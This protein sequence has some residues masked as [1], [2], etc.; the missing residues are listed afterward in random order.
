MTI[1]APAS[2]VADLSEA[3]D[4]VANAAVYSSAANAA[5]YWARVVRKTDGSVGEGVLRKL[6]NELQ[7]YKSDFNDVAANDEYRAAIG[8]A[9]QAA[10]H[11][12]NYFIALRRSELNF[13]DR[14]LEP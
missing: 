12:M 13:V 14:H 10:K 3:L 6:R 5:M 2:C 4:A 7:H 9:L 11:A 8:T 1:D